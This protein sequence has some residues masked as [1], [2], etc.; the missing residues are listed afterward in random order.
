MENALWADVWLRYG[1]D[2][3]NGK[4]KARRRPSVTEARWNLDEA[5]RFAMEVYVFCVAE[6]RTLGVREGV[7]R[8]LRGELTKDEYFDYLTKGQTDLMRGLMPF[9]AHAIGMWNGQRDEALSS[10]AAYART[11]ISRRRLREVV[12]EMKRQGGTGS[13][14]ADLQKEL[15]G[16]IALLKRAGLNPEVMVRLGPDAANA[17]TNARRGD[18]GDAYRRIAANL[19]IG[20]DGKAPYEALLEQTPGG[21]NPEETILAHDEAARKLAA[22]QDIRNNLPPREQSIL[23]L[24]VQGLDDKEIAQQLGIKRETV[25]TTLFRIRRKGAKRI[26]SDDSA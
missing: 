16:D 22:A 2:A 26:R 10:L 6:M 11:Q 15:S 21:Q 23:D 18:S 9:A 14:E 20:E 4:W 17:M 7:I 13:L 3:R 19:P 24:S 25:R 12:R 8:V 5:I 1:F